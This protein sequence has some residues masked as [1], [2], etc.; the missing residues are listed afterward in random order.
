[1]LG[2]EIS[3]AEFSLP[4]NIFCSEIVVIVISEGKDAREVGGKMLI[5]RR[6]AKN[7]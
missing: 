5:H 4:P 2:R 1:M 7:N 6:G 3:H